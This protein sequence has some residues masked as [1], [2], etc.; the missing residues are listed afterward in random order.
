MRTY[1]GGISKYIQVGEHQF[2]EDKLV[3]HW[4]D[5]MLN[6]YIVFLIMVPSKAVVY[7]NFEFSV[8]ASSCARLYDIA[9]SHLSELMSEWQFGSTLTTEQVWDTFTLLA[10]LD[11]CQSYDTLPHD[12]EQR[13][14]FMAVMHDRN[15]Q[16]IIEEQEE[17][18]H[19]CYGCM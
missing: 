13:D 19:A 4:M 14:R 7:S 11:D 15:E 3:L 8:S 10:L 17:L 6:G 9:Q 18:P 12:G 16:V 2:V 1:Y 5:L